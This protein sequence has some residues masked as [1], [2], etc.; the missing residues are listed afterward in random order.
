MKYPK[1]TVKEKNIQQHWLKMVRQ[2]LFR[3]TTKVRDQG[4]ERD[5]IQLQ[6]EPE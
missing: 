4:N 3:T 1:E 6:I 2:T 5:W